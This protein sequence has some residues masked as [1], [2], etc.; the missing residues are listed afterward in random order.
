[1]PPS[2][3]RL[4]DAGCSHY[5]TPCVQSTRGGTV[6]APIGVPGSE[7]LTDAV[8]VTSPPYTVEPC[9]EVRPIALSAYSAN[10]RLPSGPSAIP[11]DCALPPG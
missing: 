9:D 8:R 5:A 3:S 10:Q 2:E 6:T 4:S 1:L 11:W 7:L